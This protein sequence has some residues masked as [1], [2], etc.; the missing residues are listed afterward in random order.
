LANRTNWT[1]PSP[2]V[3]EKSSR[4]D[5]RFATAEDRRVHYPLVLV[6]LVLVPLVL[7]PLVLVLVLVLENPS[8]IEDEDEDEGRERSQSME[9]TFHFNPFGTPGSASGK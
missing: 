2:A 4:H 8:E 9:L 3:S 1:P 7:V 6:P 5:P